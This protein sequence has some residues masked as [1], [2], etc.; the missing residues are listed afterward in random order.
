MPDPVL[1]RL[2][3]TLRATPTGLEAVVRRGATR[4]DYVTV[5]ERAY[6]F[7]APLE[8]MLG[9]APG[10]GTRLDL[11]AR[12][13]A[14]QI[15]AD[16][17]EL[18]LR[19]ATIT[20]L[21]LARDVPA[22][23]SLD[24]A[25]GWMYVAE[26]ATLGF[27]LARAHVLRLAP[28]STHTLPTAFLASYGDDTEPR[29]RALCAEIARAAAAPHAAAVILHAAHVAARLLATWLEPAPVERA[30]AARLG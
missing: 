11:R 6:G 13:K 22:F 5:L 21:P 8:S 20:A 25:L 4:A 26:R 10:V 1:T 2:A 27:D 18:G 19:P 12:A 14:G 28:G 7:H 17:L 23:G 29:W 24:E 30:S 9:I 3:H 15:A 16:L